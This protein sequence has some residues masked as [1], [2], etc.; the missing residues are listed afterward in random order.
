MKKTSLVSLVSV[1]TIG[2]TLAG[3]ATASASTKISMV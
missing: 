3:G 2:L 1:V